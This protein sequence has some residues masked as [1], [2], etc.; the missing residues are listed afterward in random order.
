MG[1]FIGNLFGVVAAAVQGYVD[2]EDYI[3]HVIVLSR[4]LRDTCQS[5]R[6]CTVR[7]TFI[8]QVVALEKIGSRD[9]FRSLAQTEDS[10]GFR[11]SELGPQCLV[12]LQ[13][14]NVMTGRGVR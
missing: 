12:F 14:H 11:L 3:S 4:R 2:C 1:F 8:L 5:L 9:F 13:E 7:L 6:A 10:S